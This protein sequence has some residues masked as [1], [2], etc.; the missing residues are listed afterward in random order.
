MTALE[1]FNKFETQRLYEI[2]ITS[3]E[4]DVLKKYIFS[5]LLFVINLIKIGS[6]FDE[7]E[8]HQSTPA[9]IQTHDLGDRMKGFF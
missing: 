6:I 3:K 9:H 1:C 2:F 7:G 5:A 4:E 8:K